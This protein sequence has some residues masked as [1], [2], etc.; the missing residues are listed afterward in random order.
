MLSFPFSVTRVWK[1]PSASFVAYSILDIRHGIFE[2]SFPR[3]FLFLFVCFMLI[4]PLD[5]SQLLCWL[6]IMYLPSQRFF[7]FPVLVY[8][9]VYDV[10]LLLISVISVVVPLIGLLL[11]RACPSNHGMP[12]LVIAPNIYSSYG[13][14]DHDDSPFI[15]VRVP[16]PARMRTY[17]VVVRICTLAWRIRYGPCHSLMPYVIRYMWF[18]LCNF[19][20]AFS[21]PH[22]I[23]RILLSYS[24][25]LLMLIMHVDW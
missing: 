23:T 2:T 7:F 16:A 21:A 5:L 20:C 11:L 3:G 12:V 24:H 4:V 19:L 10:A 17:C 22:S 9:V 15:L 25:L 14:Y 6:F 1:V 13:S 18:A 8:V